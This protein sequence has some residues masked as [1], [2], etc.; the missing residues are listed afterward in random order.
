MAVTSLPT[1]ASTIVLIVLAV[2]ASP[3]EGLKLRRILQRVDDVYKAAGLRDR[4]RSTAMI[5]EPSMRLTVLL[6]D[7]SKRSDVWVHPEPIGLVRAMTSSWRKPVLKVTSGTHA[8]AS[9]GPN[10]FR[11]PAL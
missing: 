5:S 7:L 11:H 1:D 2:E 8:S 6:E 9:W 10:F 3:D 4:R